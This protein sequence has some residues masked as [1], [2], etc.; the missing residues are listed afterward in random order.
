MRVLHVTPVRDPRD[1]L[2]TGL[3]EQVRAEQAAADDHGLDWHAR[4]FTRGQ[5]PPAL[6]PLRASSD[7]SEPSA[8]S[9]LRRALDRRAHLTALYRWLAA[10]QS[11]YDVI[12]LRHLQYDTHRP[13]AARRIRV[14]LLSVHHT[15]EVPEIQLTPGLGGRLREIAER[16]IGVR[17]IRAGDGIVGV[18]SEITEYER[19]RAG[20]DLPTFV[21]PNGIDPHTVELLEDHRGQV[22]ELLF[23]A[24]TF[25]P[26]QGID[27]LVDAVAK[28]SDAFVLHL[29][30]T[31]PDGALPLGPLDPRVRLHGPRSRAEINQ[32]ASSAWV[33]LTALALER[34][35]MTEACSLKVREYL[36]SGLPTYAG[37]RDVF[38]AGDFY[39]RK[40]PVSMD[41]ILS[42]AHE[43][44]GRTREDVRSASL[45]SITKA[46]ILSE[47]IAQL[48]QTY[49]AES[50]RD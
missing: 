31:V 45:P 32:I 40:G 33:G 10:V 35:Q 5:L 12:L 2:L 23:V 17:A 39:F 48:A 6:E 8:G 28:S 43:M 27:L 44:R 11:E 1:P 7:T 38:A 15:L 26:W 22:P 50:T 24:S 37:H 49:R 3:L 46:T 9:V 13:A 30:G 16:T 18:T 4:I 36:A 20:V 47:V 41:A 42:Y 19:R 29:V 25:A 34:K 21:L 14:P